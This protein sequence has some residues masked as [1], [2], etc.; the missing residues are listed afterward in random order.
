MANGIIGVQEPSSG[1]VTKKL[2]TTSLTVGGNTVQRE[3][4]QIAGSTDVA[5]IEPADAPLAG[6][7]Y[8][9]PIRAIP[10][11]D[12]L[13]VS[14]AAFTSADQHSAAAAVTDAPTSTEHL[15]ISQLVV[16]VDTTMAVSFTE[17]TSGTVLLKLFVLA[18]TSAN[19]PTRVKLPTA[20]KK[21]MVQTSVSGNIAVTAIYHSE[22]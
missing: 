2:D 3:R 21:L 7:E 16:S 4:H 9:L 17:Q 20:D 8:G 19:I 10:T 14:G 6:T 22:A 11:V 18:N 15:V 13:G 5:L 12:S 1:A